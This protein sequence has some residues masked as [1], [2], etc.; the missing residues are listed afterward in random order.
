MINKVVLV[1][2]LTKDIELRK[3]GDNISVCTF[4]VACNRRYSGNNNNQNNADFINCVAWR[5]SADFLKNY[6]SKGSIVGVEG[7]IQ[8]RSYQNNQGQTVYVTEVLAD[9]VQLI[10][11]RSNS[12]NTNNVGNNNYNNYG[13]PP[14]ANPSRQTF[15]PEN[16]LED[17]DESLDI[18][19]DALPF[20]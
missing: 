7:S 19:T 9:S 17:D 15:T 5:Q 4:T 3:V 8:T 20:Y 1:G 18:N 12:T 11:G 14:A 2:R 13:N 6:A 10:G 16:N